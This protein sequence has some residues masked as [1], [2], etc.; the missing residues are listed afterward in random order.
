[1]SERIT[2]DETVEF[3]QAV[4]AVIAEAPVAARVTAPLLNRIS[5]AIATMPTDPLPRSPRAKKSRAIS[6]NS[7][8]T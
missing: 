6:A 4:I 7:L 5:T 8:T 2:I 3:W 1:M